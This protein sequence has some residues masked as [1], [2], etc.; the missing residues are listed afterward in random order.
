MREPTVIF[1]TDLEGDV[2]QGLRLASELAAERC[3]TLVVAHVVLLERADGEAM[4]YGGVELMTRDPGHALRAL[5]PTDTSVPHRSLLLYGEVLDQLAGIA[6]DPSVELVVM[7]TRPRGALERLLGRSLVERLGA[8]IDCPIVTYRAG[9]TTPTRRSAGAH[10][11][12]SPSLVLQLTLD[13]RVDALLD[14]MDRRVYMAAS[15]ARHRSVQRAVA[16]LAAAQGPFERRVRDE[17]SLELREHLHATKAA[18]IEIWLDVPDPLDEDASDVTPRR[19]LSIGQE[20]NRSPD[21]DAWMA[22]VARDGAA[23]SLPMR[24]GDGHP[25]VVV[26]G[27]RVPRTSGRSA[28]LALTFDARRG[29]LRILAQPGPTP[30]AETYAFDE[31]G[32]MLS[33]SRFADQLRRVGLL[34]A[35]GQTLGQLRVCDPGTRF[36]DAAASVDLESWPLTHMAAAAV[37]GHDGVNTRGYRDYRGVPVIGAWRWIPS[38]HFGVAAEMDLSEARLSRA[39]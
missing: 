39:S 36:L 35:A 4:L 16:S 2:E 31:R 37:A 19:A 6:S 14:W 29:F 26:A 24:A 38:F 20:A 13:A 18:G 28:V 25:P 7:E 1:A 3:A 12:L 30:S 15:I 33:D 34:P 10:T 22:A 32:V 27:A 9:S 23:V 8:R 21:W 17:L 5:S 11:V